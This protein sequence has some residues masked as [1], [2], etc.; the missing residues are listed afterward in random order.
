MSEPTERSRI[1]KKPERARPD[2]AFR[3]AVLDE[4]LV[5]HLSWVERGAPCV[6]PMAYVRVGD[7]L[8]LH[9]SREQR[10]LVHMAAGGEVCACVTLVD[11]LVLARS[12]KNHSLNYRCVVAWG[13]G[14]E[15]DELAAKRASL[16][17]LVEHV[18]PGRG[19]GSRAP[20]EAELRATRVCAIRLDEWSCKQRDDGPRDYPQDLALAHWAGIVPLGIA[21]GEP[22][23]EVG[24][25]GELALP[26]HVRAWRR[27]RAPH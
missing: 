24:P 13:R 27:G 15:I 22:R 9:G 25:A 23:Q 7:E 1:R 18:V 16:A 2:P 4:G 5:C 20:T 17:A 19:G 12:A 26:A 14:R 10:A 8:H 6:L 11:A 21:V 3:D